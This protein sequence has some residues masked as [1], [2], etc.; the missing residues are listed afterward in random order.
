M[1]H[2]EKTS[3]DV[4]FQNTCAYFIQVLYLVFT[5][6]VTTLLKTR[7]WAKWLPAVSTSQRLV[8]ML[9]NIQ[10]ILCPLTDSTVW[11]FIS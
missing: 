5:W 10:Y 1:W 3:V 6:E 2:K 4:V 8:N 9:P 11:Q 7:H